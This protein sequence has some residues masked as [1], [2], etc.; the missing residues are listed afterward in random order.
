VP[1][2]VVGTLVEIPVLSEFSTREILWFS[3]LNGRRSS[4]KGTRSYAKLKIGSK[5]LC[6]RDHGLQQS[7][8]LPAREKDGF[9]MRASSSCSIEKIHSL[10]IVAYMKGLQKII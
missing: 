5:M 4:R 7:R 10:Q 9:S 1:T 3:L 2:L 8:D 6:I